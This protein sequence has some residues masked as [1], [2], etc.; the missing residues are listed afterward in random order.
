MCVCAQPAEAP[1]VAI[2][3]QVGFHN[4][5]YTALLWSFHSAGANVTMFIA[6]GATWQIE[7][8]LQSW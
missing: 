2:L 6:T 5:V 7:D 4:E 3:N 1:R 8:V